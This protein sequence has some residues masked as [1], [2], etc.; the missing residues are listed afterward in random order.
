VGQQQHDTLAEG[1]ALAVEEEAR[2]QPYAV[3]AVIICI[4]AAT[5]YEALVVVEEARA[6]GTGNCCPS[7]P[8][9]LFAEIVTTCLG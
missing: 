7:W 9:S 1:M 4:Q 8:S 5:L 2:L 6:C 3:Q